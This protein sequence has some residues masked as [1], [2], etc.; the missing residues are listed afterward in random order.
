MAGRG[1]GQIGDLLGW[2]PVGER[3]EARRGSWPRV[4]H[5]DEGGT[6]A[7]RAPG[8]DGHLRGHL[9]RL[10]EGLRGPYLPRGT[11]VQFTALMLM[12]PEFRGFLLS[13]VSALLK[14]R[15][16]LQDLGRKE[17]Q[18]P[19]RGR[20]VQRC[21]R[22]PAPASCLQTRVPTP[23]GRVRHCRRLGGLGG[24]GPESCHTA[25]KHFPPFSQ[26]L[27]NWFHEKSLRLRALGSQPTPRG[28]VASLVLGLLI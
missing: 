18:V 4:P 19:A 11:R 22:A 13:C 25:W 21:S 16:F 20:P 24:L 8:E 15:N 7:L 12:L 23:S 5:G 27:R 14:A 26:R 17:V 3:A 6:Q 9:G 28:V 1:N 10:S 2:S